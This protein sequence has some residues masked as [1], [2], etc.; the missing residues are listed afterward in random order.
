MKRMMDIETNNVQV[1]PDGT[2]DSGTMTY[3]AYKLGSMYIVLVKSSIKW[4]E[5]GNGWK[6]TIKGKPAYGSWIVGNAL[7]LITKGVVAGNP[8]SGVAIIYLI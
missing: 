6:F 1:T 8:G 7:S 2:V 3:E 4:D 5:S